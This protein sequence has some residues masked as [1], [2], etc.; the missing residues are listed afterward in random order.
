MEKGK[1]NKYEARNSASY[2]REL[3]SRETRDGQ[4]ERFI[5]FSFKDLDRTPHFK[6]GRSPDIFVASR[7]HR[8]PKRGVAL[9]SYAKLRSDISPLGAV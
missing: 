2:K 9:A 3:K 6:K 7:R 8:A 1:P 5:A 4:K